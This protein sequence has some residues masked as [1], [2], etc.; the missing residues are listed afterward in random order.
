L[1]RDW[2]L[3]RCDWCETEKR[4]RGLWEDVAPKVNEDG[5]IVV[6]LGD[7]D[8]PDVDEK[9]YCGAECLVSDL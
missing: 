9:C 3:Y 5:W 4:Y 1:S 2:T 6:T 7:P 8:S